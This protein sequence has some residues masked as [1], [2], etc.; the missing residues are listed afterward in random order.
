MF[1]NNAYAYN[2]FNLPVYINDKGIAYK[3]CISAYNH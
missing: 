1:Q 2:N 3:P